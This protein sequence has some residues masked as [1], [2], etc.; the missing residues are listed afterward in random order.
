MLLVKL[1]DPPDGED[2]RCEYAAAEAHVA[3][4]SSGT[5][6]SAAIVVGGSIAAFAVLIRAEFTYGVAGA[7]TALALGAVVVIAMWRYNWSR[8]KVSIDNC[9]IRMRE[10][11]LARG[12]RKNTILYLLTKSRDERGKLERDPLGQGWRLDRT[13]K[14]FPE[15]PGRCLLHLLHGIWD[16][17]ICKRVPWRLRA[18]FRDIARLVRACFN[19][20][21]RWLQDVL[22][23][24]ARLL[25][26]LP[27]SGQ[28]VLQ[29]TA[30]LVQLGWLAIIAFAWYEALSGQGDATGC[31]GWAT[32]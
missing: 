11:E 15:A 26:R 4:L 18:L 23:W 9:W 19:R 29:G 17:V 1:R 25:P 20:L 7:V 22:R 10:I 12:M 3:N 6:Q 8:H 21:P 27:H 13:Y 32:W 2:L 14:E 16:K 24:M 28:D 5:W 30:W 31:L